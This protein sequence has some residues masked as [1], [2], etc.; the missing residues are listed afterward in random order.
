[1]MSKRARTDKT[2][3]NGEEQCPELAIP[4]YEKEMEIFI[5][6]R[7]QQN[8]LF[9]IKSGD[10]HLRISYHSED[11]T[12]NEKIISLFGDLLHFPVLVYGWKGGLR[13]YF[14]R[15]EDVRSAEWYFEG[16]EP[17]NK[18][19]FYSYYTSGEGTVAFIID[20]LR[21]S[22]ELFYMS[23]FGGTF[24]SDALEAYQGLRDRERGV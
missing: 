19:W 15:P 13:V 14:Y 8:V 21:R 3:A 12:E 6:T 24:T 2:E 7:L 18:N 10:K 5:R 1:M 23:R 4:R 11:Q 22:Q 16:D 9:G 17:K 20:L